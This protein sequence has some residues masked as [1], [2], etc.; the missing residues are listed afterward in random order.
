MAS[1]LPPKEGIAQEGDKGGF[2][3]DANV[4]EEQ[5]PKLLATDNDMVIPVGKVV[6]SRSALNH[7]WFR[8]PGMASIL[9]PKE[10]IAQ[11]WMTSSE[12]TPITVRVVSEQA[13]AD[14]LTEAKTKYAAIDNGA[15]L[16]DAR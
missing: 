2:T 6:P 16:A 13:Y 4:D 11:E 15:R 5:Q 1:I 7:H 8:R 14:W 12:V 3:F 9:P 10:G